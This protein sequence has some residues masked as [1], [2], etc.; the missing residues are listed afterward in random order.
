[1]TKMFILLN[2]IDACRELLEE[3]SYRLCDSS[4]LHDLIPFIHKQEQQSIQ[5]QI[6]GKNVS[7][8]FD[9]TTHVCET[10]A[11]IL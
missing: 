9:G 7:V 5:D 11:I 2:K 4:H 8:I 3:N 6:C 10:L 1:M